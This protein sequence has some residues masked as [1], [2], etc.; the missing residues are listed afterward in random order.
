[1]KVKLLHDT[2]VNFPAGTE[3]EVSEAEASRL[4]AFGLAEEVK[5][6]APKKAPKKAK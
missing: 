5:E 6:Q 4:Q 1:M 3:L 2:R